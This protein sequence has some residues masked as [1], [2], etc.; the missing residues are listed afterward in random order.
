MTPRL[1]ARR[2]LVIGNGGAGKSTFS[3]ALGARTGLPVT[4]LD[5]LH[6]RP[7][8]T[9]P[10]APDWLRTLERV[11]AAD[12]WILDGN[13]RGT[14]TLRAAR[15]DAL[16]LLDPPTRTCLWRIVRRRFSGR[17]TPDLAS[18]CEEQ[19]EPRYVRY[20]ANYRRTHL[21]DA[22]AACEAARTCGKTVLRIR[23]RVDVDRIAVA[24]GH[25]ACT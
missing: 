21:P 2:V 14:M 7:G 9:P 19:L 15:A 11:V 4:H 12:A 3:A 22:L 16:V 6:W 5:A 24:L 13:Y 17:G 1:P 23:G 10:P 8:W 25:A 18:G 20:V